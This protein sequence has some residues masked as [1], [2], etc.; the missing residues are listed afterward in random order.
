M[1]E[2]R[3]LIDEAM[4]TESKEKLQETLSRLL[5]YLN[6]GEY[7]IVGSLAIRHHLLAAG[8]EYPY[9]PINEIDLITTKRKYCLS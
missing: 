6:P 5:P 9:P 1:S 2:E 4:P 8:K 7:K 3:K